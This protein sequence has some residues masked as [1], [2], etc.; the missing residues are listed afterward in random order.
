MSAAF[1]LAKALES[2]FKE[3][4]LLEGFQAIRDA[5]FEEYTDAKQ[6]DGHFDSA[7][8][9]VWEVCF[10]SG[11]SDGQDFDEFFGLATEEE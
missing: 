3:K 7:L 8:R 11:T 9:A 10:P 1:L 6:F 2:Q 5:Y 4:T